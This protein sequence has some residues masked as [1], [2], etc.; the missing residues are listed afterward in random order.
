MANVAV[1]GAG[2][3]IRWEVR[4]ATSSNLITWQYLN[5]ILQD[6]DMPYTKTVAANGWIMLAHE[7]WEGR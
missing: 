3:P 2:S 6:A 1:G 7:Q 4:V 5:T